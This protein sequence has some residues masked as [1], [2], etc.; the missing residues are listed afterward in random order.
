MTRVLV[1]DGHPDPGPERFCHALADAYA[2]GATAAAHDVRRLRLCDLEF[3]D[4]TRRDDWEGA[5]APAAIQGVQADIL[6][7]QH[8]VI[9]YPLWLGFM[10]A[11]LKALFEQ[12]FRP[13]FAFGQRERTIGVG[14]LKGRTARIIV[15]M[16]MPAAFYRGFY[17][18]HA[19]T[20][21]R[22]NILSFVGIGPTRSNI[23]GNA[24]GISDLQCERWLDKVSA[25]G[26]RAR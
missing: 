17:F 11:R 1:L 13:G 26:S 10:P 18:A 8:L 23:V 6:W 2:A 4:L 25:L 20:A 14:R 24:E 21:L 9:I 15:T 12:T 22:R 3:P 5:P 16:G 19:L 7:A